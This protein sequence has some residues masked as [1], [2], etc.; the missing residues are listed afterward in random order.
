MSI[1]HCYD[2]CGILPSVRHLE[3]SLGDPASRRTPR[4]CPRNN[5]DL[6]V[7]NSIRTL[8]TLLFF[9]LAV[10]SGASTIS[11]A[12][13]AK[14]PDAKSGFVASWDGAK[15]HYLEAGKVPATAPHPQASIL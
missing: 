11:V 6:D 2:W 14:N 15:I 1:G 3:P 10:H 4:N 13:T 9:L 7:S 8:S 5:E 12:R